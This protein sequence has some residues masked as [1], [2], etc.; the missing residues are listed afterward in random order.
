MRKQ[1]G[2]GSAVQVE[3]LD[4]AGLGAAVADL[5]VPQSADLAPGQ[6]G[7]R[8]AQRG[9]VGLDG[10]QVVGAAVVQVVGVGALAVQRVRGDHDTAQVIDGV[11]RRGEGGHLVCAVHLDL[12]QRQV[13]GV[14]EDRD[15][16]GLPPALVAGAAQRLAVHGQ[17]RPVLITRAHIV[18]GRPP[19]GIAAS[20]DPPGQGTLQRGRIDRR[21]H[22]SERGRMRRR[23]DH[24]HRLL[25]AAGPLGDRRIRARAGQHGA[26]REQQDRLQTVTTTPGTARIRDGGQSLQ[27]TDRL[28][29]IQP[30]G[31]Q[32]GLGDR[33]KRDGRGR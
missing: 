21:E 1:P 12:R 5:P 14:V 10:E 11:Q 22:P 6:P 16:L 29:R 24:G 9:L 17:H 3:H 33:A 4:R 7:Q 19:A 32:A 28:G 27:Q 13:I 15:Q 31:R 26:D 30:L 18:P 25:R 8:A 20:H 2:L 23:T